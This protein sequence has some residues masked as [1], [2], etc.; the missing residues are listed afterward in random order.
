VP[1]VAYSGAQKAEAIALA[2]VVGAEAA[3][4]Q[5]RITV[6][7]IRRWCELAGKVP[8]DAIGSTDWQ[9]LGD[10]ARSQ[11]AARLA[12]GKVSAREAAIVAGIADRNSRE[13]PL[14]ESP[15]DPEAQA[16]TDGLTSALE[17]RYGAPS[18]DALD[19]LILDTMRWLRDADSQTPMLE[20][21][22]A[23]LVASLPPDWA[24]W[25]AERKAVHAAE[26]EAALARIARSRPAWESFFRGEIT[27]EQRTAWIAEGI[28]PLSESD[29]ALVA[30]AEAFLREH[31]A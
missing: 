15:P 6:G 30:A 27:E 18:D 14:P 19:M 20:L 24:A 29:A 17:A 25:H 1:R 23:E 22:P 21:G 26:Q 8:R 16:W 11:V 4:R 2:T 9:A 3:S 12:A 13:A 31:A 5:L 28:N 10:L 7:A